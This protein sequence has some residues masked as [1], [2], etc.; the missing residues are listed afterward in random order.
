MNKQLIF[1]SKQSQPFLRTLQL[2]LGKEMEINHPDRI[3]SYSQS[4]EWIYL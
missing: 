3:V 2:N 4:R 1:F